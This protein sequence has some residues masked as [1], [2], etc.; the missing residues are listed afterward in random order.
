MGPMK[1]EEN[2]K[3]EKNLF[4]FIEKVDNSVCILDLNNPEVI[5][6]LVRDVK[7]ACIGTSDE[8][9]SKVDLLSIFNQ[10]LDTSIDRNLELTSDNR[11]SRYF[12]DN[13]ICF[14]CGKIGHVDRKCPSKNVKTCILCSGHDHTKG[15]CPQIVCLRCGMC[16]HR[17]K[18]CKTLYKSLDNNSKINKVDNGLR[19]KMCNK[20]PNEHSMFDCPRKWRVYLTSSLENLEMNRIRKICVNCFSDDHFLDDCYKHRHSKTSIF[21]N[22][23]YKYIKKI[24][25][26]KRKEDYFEKL[27]KIR[28]NLKREE[29]RKNKFKISKNRNRRNKK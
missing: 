24:H 18:D 17:I 16:G 11:A 5:K 29:R 1:N 26:T 8:E 21:C 14:N 12:A 19:F 22:S 28:E 25:G 23:F 6:Y 20:C 7:G 13:R 10:S 3:K 9:A 2:I 4:D 15:S 27:Y